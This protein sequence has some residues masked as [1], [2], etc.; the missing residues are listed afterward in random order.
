VLLKAVLV[1][2]FADRQ[3]NVEPAVIEYLSPRME[4]S[5]AAADRVVGAID[6]L[7]LATHRK[8][9]RPLAAEA[10]ASLNESG[11]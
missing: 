9:T 10:L 3:L 6:G 8:V 4:R 7:A 2:L 11:E 1:K 5:M